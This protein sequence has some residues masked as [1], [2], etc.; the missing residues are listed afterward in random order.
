MPSGDSVAAPNVLWLLSDEHSFRYLSFLD[1]ADP[2]DGGEPVRTP[3]LDR[4]AA[5]GTVFRN[6]YCQMPLCTPSR[7]G[8]LT[9]RD[10]DRCGGQGNESVLPPDLPTLPGYLAEV[11]GYETCLL[12]KMHFGGSRQFG[13]FRHR[14]YGDLGGVVGGHQGD[15]L[16]EWYAYGGHRDRRRIDLAGIGTVPESFLQE[17]I[18]TREA[19]AFLREHRHRA[20]QQ[21][22]LLCASFSR[23][24]YPWTAPRRHFE[25]Y[26]PQGITSPRV[27]RTGDTVA[28][29]YTAHL[30][31]STRTGS[32]SEEDALRARAAYFGC[33][34][35]LDE[36][37]GDFLAL[38]DRD[39]FLDNTIVVYTTDHGSMNGEHGLWYKS[40]WHEASSHVPLIIQLPEQR[41]GE[42][43][44]SQVKTPVSL[45]DLF[46]TLSGLCGLAP[47]AGLDGVDTSRHVRSGAPEFERAPVVCQMASSWRMLRRGQYKFVTFRD[48]PDVLFD[49]EDDPDEQRN[50]AE[51]PEHASLVAELRAHALADFDF[52]AVTRRLAEAQ[53]DL[54]QRFPW[55]V[56]GRTP[57]QMILPDGRLVE[58]DVALYSPVV[59][60][61]S[62]RD[63]FDDWPDP[64]IPESRRSQ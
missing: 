63:A 34:D 23:P 30:R 53:R 25:R 49:L 45:G 51:L 12:G 20:P 16:L 61:E 21:P 22:W 7:F 2:R 10:H 48:G 36:V 57:N 38:L 15:P 43:G 62:A 27:G 29:P 1:P 59:L 17:Q 4:L 41:R 40:T 31:A 37:L 6:A 9:G 33:I 58:A 50:L 8:M 42:V 18:I 64:A 56:R 54:A 28:H 19:V 11:G 52:G 3:T 35:F 24:H 47:P 55:R 44:P 60:A 32:V 13:G 46:P 39:G 26:W 5:R 14:P